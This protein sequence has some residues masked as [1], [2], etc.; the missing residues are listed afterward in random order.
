[1]HKLLKEE[2]ILHIL[3]Y[4][5]R[6]KKKEESYYCKIVVGINNVFSPI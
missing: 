2:E 6:N 4:F 3:K 5:S 1:M